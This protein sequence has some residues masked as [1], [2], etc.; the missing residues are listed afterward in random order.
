MILATFQDVVSTCF[1]WLL[2]II[3]FCTWGMKSFFAHNPEVKDAAKKAA[4]N[5]AMSIIDKLLK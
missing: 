1:W 4:S 2:I 3:G 5:K